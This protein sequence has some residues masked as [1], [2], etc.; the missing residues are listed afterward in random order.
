MED[1]MRGRYNIRYFPPPPQVE[2]LRG[3][4]EALRK[5]SCLAPPAAGEPAIKRITRTAHSEAV[6]VRGTGYA[7]V[8]LDQPRGAGLPSRAHLR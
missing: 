6:I 5:A 1:C 4:S 2:L 8:H 7:V 3:R